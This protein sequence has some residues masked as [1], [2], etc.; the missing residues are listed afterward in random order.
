[1]PLALQML[2]EQALGSLDR[3]RQPITEPVQLPIE[4]GQASDVVGSSQ[5]QQ[6][7]AVMIEHTELMMLTAPVDAGEHRPGNLIGY[8]SSSNRPLT[9]LADP[10]GRSFRCFRCPARGTTPTGQSRSA[11]AGRDRSAAGPHP[12]SR[13]QGPLL[14]VELNQREPPATHH[15]GE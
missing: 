4:L 7:L 9:S 8:T 5:L 10:S 15:V 13:C 3:D 12:G 11:T 6:P 14:T 2:N 1:M